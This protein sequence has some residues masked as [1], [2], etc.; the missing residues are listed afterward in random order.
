MRNINPLQAARGAARGL[1]LPEVMISLAITSTLLV[2][3]AAAFCAS[4]SAIE[5]ND[6][7]FRCTQAS[8]VTMNQ[9]LAEIRNCDSM[10]MSVANTIK[11]IR[12]APVPGVLN[13][14]Y[15]RP[16]NEASR[17][18]VYDSAN[19][20]IT[21]QISY[22]DGTFSPLYELTSNVNACG[23]GPAE[24]GLDYNNAE[25]PVRVPILVTVS[26]GGNSVVLDGSAAPRRA[27][28]Y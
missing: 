14:Q 24:M 26:T 15:V 2:A 9:I 18:F 1:S 10:D 12:Q 21:L 3:V 27:M 13:Q 23:F 19:K 6:A 8:R 25:I 11:V 16:A 5:N 7:F 4:A 22:L 20:R 28:K 17:S